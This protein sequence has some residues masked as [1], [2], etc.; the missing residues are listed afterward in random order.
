MRNWVDGGR[1]VYTNDNIF[2]CTH[3][4]DE[5]LKGESNN[6]REEIFFKI[7]ELDHIPLLLYTF[8]TNYLLNV[9]IIHYQLVVFQSE[10][11]EVPG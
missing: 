9:I 4:Y 3:K 2:V 1:T 7:L 10:I 6:K 5:R 8:E 11:E